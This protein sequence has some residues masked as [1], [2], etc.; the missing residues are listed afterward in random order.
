LNTEESKR[1][2]ITFAFGSRAV[3]SAQRGLGCDETVGMD[4][5]YNSALVGCRRCCFGGR[6]DK[7]WGIEG[8]VDIGKTV[9]S[10]SME[11]Q[12]LKVVSDGGAS[13]GSERPVLAGHDALDGHGEGEGEQVQYCV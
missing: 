3:Q 2:E 7:S 12:E 10:L 5:G 9:V 8:R 13:G 4:D 1:K 11:G 6:K